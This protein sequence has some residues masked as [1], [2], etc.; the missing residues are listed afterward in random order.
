L[1]SDLVA[2][3][4]KNVMSE[5]R[6]QKL[7][8]LETRLKVPGDKS[9]SHRAILLAG[10]AEG[11]SRISGFLTSEDCLCTL[12]AMQALGAKVDFLSDNTFDVTGVGGECQPVLETID[13]GNSGTL[14]RLIS[15]VLAAQPFPSRLSGDVSL[16]SRPMK[17]IMEPLREMGAQIESETHNDCAPLL[18]HGAHLEAIAYQS[19]VASA[20]VKSCLLL[21]GLFAEGNTSVTE[22]ALS[23]DHTE[24]MMRY[25]YIPLQ[26]RDLTVTVP[27]GSLPQA[28]DFMVPGD[29]SSAAFWMAAA[30]AFPGSQLFIEDVGLNPTRTGL[31]SVLMRMG[32]QIREFI[33][34]GKEM[35]P[36]GNL[37]IQGRNL[38]GTLIEGKEIANVIDEIPIIAVL[39]AL[40]EGETIIKDAAELRVKETDRIAAITQ[41]LRAFGAE[42]EE[43]SDGMIIQGG[44]PLTSTTVESFG[45]H[46]I[47]MAFA[48]L[49][50]FCEGQTHILNTAC[51]DT[52]YPQFE[53]HLAQ[54]AA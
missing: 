41:N 15:G 46:R 49:G 10:L 48:I 42:V 51:I 40:A 7:K 2:L 54:L 11:T 17:R 34:T 13:C 44:R 20:Q 33:E 24:R 50:L 16:N 26:N 27:G 43:T 8:K 22:P 52:S 4:L 5:L 14:M 53:Q 45:D 29:F 6:V 1:A 31:V 39:A 3:Q 36:H 35:E 12:R 25:F 37:E 47:A 32:A 30:A 28:R 23:R 9:M 19:P 21:A 38:R 18:L